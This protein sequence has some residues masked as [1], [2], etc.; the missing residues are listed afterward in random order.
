VETVCGGDFVRVDT[1]SSDVVVRDQSGDT[2]IDAT[3]IRAIQSPVKK[4]GA[5]VG[6]IV[7]AAVD[8]LIIGLIFVFSKTDRFQIGQ[9]G[10]T[11]PQ[12]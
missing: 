4:Y 5:V 6:L 2:R 7:G 10:G 8:V 12:I 1:I 11:P 9:L 3:M